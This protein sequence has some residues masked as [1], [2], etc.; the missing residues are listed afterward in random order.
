MLDPQPSIYL[1]RFRALSPTGRCHTFGAAAD[2]YVRGEGCGLVVLKRLSDA[3]ADGDRIMAVIRGA[4]TNHDGRSSGLTV[5]SGAA[6][7]EV[8]EQ[9]LSDART[10]STG[11]RPH[12][13]ARHRH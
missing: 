7:R 10:R 13:G 5:P 6:Q 12:R 1:S 9:A 4:A 8:M 3:Q 2:G 11:H